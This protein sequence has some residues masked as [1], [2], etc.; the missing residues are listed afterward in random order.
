M[1]DLRIFR[2]PLFAAASGAALINGLLRFALLFLFVFYFQGPLGYSPIEAGIRLAPMAL[3][4][5]VSAPIAGWLADRHGSRGLAFL[6]MVVTAIGLALMTTLGP[7]SSYWLAA[8][9][10]ALVGV[11]SGLFNS[12]NT[13]AMMGV[14][15]ANR[16]GVAAGARTMLQNTGAVISISFVLAIVTA[17]IPKAVL[18]KI[19]SGVK[20]GLPRDQVNAFISNMHIALWVLAASSILGAIVSLLRPSH[21]QE[22]V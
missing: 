7:S 11:G 9:W 12:P 10:L 5:L 3:A 22:A 16:R 20:S 21:R 14:V 6:G 19:F 8:A 1:L 17:G 2:N 4:M 18:F 13:S 15:P